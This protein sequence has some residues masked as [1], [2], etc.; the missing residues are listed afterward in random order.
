ATR[1]RNGGGC[2]AP[3]IGAPGTSARTVPSSATTAV[4]N[5]TS[6]AA[7]VPPTANVGPTMPASAGA[8]TSTGGAGSR[9]S[10]RLVGR[11]PVAPFGGPSIRNRAAVIDGNWVSVYT[12]WAT[13]GRVV[14]VSMKRL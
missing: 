4:V 8:S 7:S 10:S 1:W 9:T 5:V 13:W 6:G 2:G 12:T 3:A 11:V 14:A